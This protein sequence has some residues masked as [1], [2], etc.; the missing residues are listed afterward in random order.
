MQRRRRTE[1]KRTRTGGGF[2]TRVMLF[3]SAVIIL[4]GIVS[5]FTGGDEL[6]ATVLATPSPTPLTAAFDE[7]VETREISLPAEVWYCL[8]SGIFSSEAAAQEKSLAYSDRGAPG[9][10]S[11]EGGKFRVLLSAYASREDAQSVK[12]KLAGQQAVETYIYE[13]VRPA[14]HLQLTGMRGQLDVLDAAAALLP[15]LARSWRETALT[16]DQ[17]QASLT[18][19][20]ELA[21][22]QQEQCHVML[23]VLQERFLSPMPTLPQQLQALLTSLM[24]VEQL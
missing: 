19:V 8:Q 1:R 9:F 4:A 24:E 13:M 16:L 2:A 7:T 23:N 12:E 21:A 14:L 17:G 20:Q 10:V 5:R 6:T 11:P 15:E 18:E 3:F 22:E